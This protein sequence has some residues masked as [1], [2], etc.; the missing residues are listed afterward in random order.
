MMLRMREDMIPMPSKLI[1]SESALSL[2]R[3]SL[4]QWGLLGL[5]SGFLGGVSCWQLLRLRPRRTVY[6]YFVR[7]R[8]AGLWPRLLRALT[9]RAKG[10][11]CFIDASYIRVHQSGAN[12]R[13]GQQ[14][15]ALGISRGG[16]TTKI[17]ALVEGQRRA[18]KL[19]LTAGNVVDITM[20][21]ALVAD[22]DCKTCG[23]LVP[24]KGYDADALRVL[25]I[26]KDIFPCLGVSRKRVEK[27]SFHKGYYRHRHHVKNILPGSSAI[28]ASRPA[29]INLHPPSSPSSL[30]VL[31][32]IGLSNVTLQTPPNRRQC[33]KCL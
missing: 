3:R 27:R 17:H 4:F 16:L 20:A 15:Q 2:S 32:S 12:P 24:N 31:S 6:G 28:V 19:L 18:L 7:W 13:G 25:L 11:L 5:I 29:T 8:E 14:A 30:L 9:Q 22:L 33:P 23:T 26:E 21:P 1:G 10:R